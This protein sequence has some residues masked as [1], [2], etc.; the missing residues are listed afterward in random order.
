MTDTNPKENRTRRIQVRLTESEYKTADGI[1]EKCGLTMSRY[2]RKVITGHHP[3]A[4]MTQR[5]ADAIAAL[6]DA[7]GELVHVKNALNTRNQEERRR[8]FRSDDFM[9]YWLQ[10]VDTLM[11]RWN[12]IIESLS[13]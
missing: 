7:R 9:R 5:E 12:N 8:L 10:K 4:R 2:V 6:N 3:K 13:R 11:E 1:A